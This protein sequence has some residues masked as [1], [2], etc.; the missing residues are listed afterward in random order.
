MGGSK[1]KTGRPVRASVRIA[2]STL[3]KIYG[4]S[5]R[6]QQMINK[7]FEKGKPWTAVH[8]TYNKKGN[9]TSARSVMSAAFQPYY[10]FNAQKNV[11]TNNKR[12]VNKAITKSLVYKNI[13]DILIPF[14]GKGNKMR[15][16]VDP[17]YVTYAKNHANIK[18]A[19]LNRNTKAL[20]GFGLLYNHYPNA[21]TRYINVIAGYPSYGHVIMNKIVQNA[22]RNGRKRV[23]L[24]AV[25]QGPN[26]NKDPL[27]KWYEAKGF[28]KAGP[29]GANSLLPMSKVL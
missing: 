26:A 5:K 15:G 8:G 3:K 14:V 19:V 11:V 21:N 2:K 9:N 25:V 29:L 22:I 17:G 16:G 27:V 24:S 10:R 13:I 4:T 18:Y 1:K 6:K 7:A 28:V 23:N 12:N 20:R